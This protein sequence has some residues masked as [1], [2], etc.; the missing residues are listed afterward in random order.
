MKNTPKH[1]NRLIDET[2]P[3]LL[4]HAHNPVDWYP[5]GEE[6]LNLAKELDKPILLSIGYSACHWCHVMERESFENEE[7]A[8]IMNKHYINI[9]VD[10][11]ER[12]D[13]D[14]IYMSAV[15]IMTGSGGW[16]MTV[17]LTPDRKPFY[18]GTYFPPDD[19]Y[20]RPGFPK[21]LVAVKDAYQNKRADIDE[22]AEKLVSHINQISNPE[23]VDDLLLDDKIIEQAFYHY[24]NRFDSQHGGFGQAPKFPPGM[25]LILLL[26]YWKRSGNSRALH[27]VEFTLEKMARGGMY[28]QLGGGFHRYSTDEIWLVPHFEKMLYDN[29]LLT[30]AYLEAFQA[31]SK[32]FYRE[33]VEETL[34]YVLR[35]MYNQQNG[36][37]YSTQDADSEGVEGKFFVWTPGEVEQILGQADA[38]IFCDFYDVTDHGNFEHQN[39]LWVK[40]PADLYAKKIKIDQANLVNILNRCKK[41]LFEIRDKRIKPGLDDKILT[42]WNGL[43]IRS[44]GL[45]YQILGDLRYLEAAEKSAKFILTELVRKNGHLL[46]THRAGKSHLNACLEDYS[47]FIAGLIELYQASFDPYWLR[48]ADR[49][50]QIMISQFWDPQN[51]GFFFTGKDYP[52]LIVRSKSAYDGATPSGASMAIHVLLRL[53]ILLNQPDLIEKA[54]T[55]FSLYDHAMK[56]APSGSAQMLC[57]VDFL[58]D[59]PKE[60]A[61]VGNPLSEQTQEILKNIHRRFVP[62]K[63]VA[64]LNPNTED[65]QKI[66]ELIPLLASKTSIDGKTTIYVCQNYACQLPT[67]DVGDLDKLL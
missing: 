41:K 40:T 8:A 17:F 5:W 49:L 60:I 64:L 19:R 10:R 32:P 30:V 65:R 35:E 59:T 22:Q 33:V 46:R 53:A 26:R 45:A 2:S 57:G 25:G 31:T 42:S 38:K 67:T 18:G 63:V 24:Q 47:Y 44:M 14:E 3:Y 36:G 27:I 23:S 21:L 11:E 9:K 43:M 62:N 16:P 6:A 52:E 48:E 1:T 61:I 39:I 29:S 54:K 28:D 12:P 66:E 4:Q 37:F 20:G 7:I 55:T 58:I 56:T 13:L 15:Q 50:N 51:G 34:D